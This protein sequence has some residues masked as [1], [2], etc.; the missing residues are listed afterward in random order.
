MRGKHI[1][2]GLL[3]VLLLAGCGERNVRPDSDSGLAFEAG[4]RIPQDRTIY[5]IQGVVYEDAESLVRQTAPAQATMYYQGAYGYG[6]YWGPQL[7]GK[8]LVRLA[9]IHTDPPTGLAL[10]GTA[11]ILKTTDTKATNLRPGDIVT[12]KCRAQ[13]EAVAATLQNENFDPDTYETWEL[14]YCRLA[15]PTIGYM[16][17]EDLDDGRTNND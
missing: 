15:N 2:L 16:P 14:D 7:G 1:I 12:F 8:G 6:S 13:Y 3:L 9:V 17:L 11:V 10:P 4:A 5:E